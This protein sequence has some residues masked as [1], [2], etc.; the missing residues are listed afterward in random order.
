MNNTKKNSLII[1]GIVL[2]IFVML[3]LVYDVIKTEPA[4]TN[5]ID[6]NLEDQNTGL[7]NMLNE[8]FDNVEDSENKSETKVE[9][10]TNVN[11]NQE[12]DN[13]SSTESVTTRQEKAIQLVK[14]EWGG[15]DGVY[16][17][18]ESIDSQGR[19]IVSVR[20][21]KTT[22][23]LAFFLVDVETGLVTKQ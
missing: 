6:T 15:E 10:E 8:L 21:K 18:N 7:V 4:N 20:D 1:I 5:S 22:N 23:S 2:T 16:F 12:E 11:N 14:E 19:Y 17:S 13:V 9:N 3:Y